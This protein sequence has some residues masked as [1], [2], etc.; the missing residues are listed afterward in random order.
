MTTSTDIDRNDLTP[1]QPSRHGPATVLTYGRPG[2]PLKQEVLASPDLDSP[3]DFE[4]L[5]PTPSRS[6]S[7]VLD[8]TQRWT[9]LAREAEA[10]EVSVLSI[11]S[12]E[13]DY[14]TSLLPDSP[15]EPHIHE[16]NP[17]EWSRTSSHLGSVISGFSE[18]EFVENEHD[19]DETRNIREESVD[20]FSE[21]D[22]GET[23]S[24]RPTSAPYPPTTQSP[25]PTHER[26]PS[27]SSQFSSSVEPP[28]FIQAPP[29]DPLPYPLI[30]SSC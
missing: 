27:I 2:S 22:Y 20:R 25:S 23:T 15:E 26:S 10:D 16:V 12:E 19:Y 17:D 5:S 21:I 1:R 30:S 9:V 29:S 13:R 11:T 28:P 14:Y 7:R 24:I 4:P 6:G 8:Q 18:G 3:D